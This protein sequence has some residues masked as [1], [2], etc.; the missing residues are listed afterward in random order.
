[1]TRSRFLDLGLTPEQLNLV[2]YFEPREPLTNEGRAGVIEHVATARPALTVFDAYAGLLGVHDLDP[3][4]ERDIE[5]INRHVVD[6]FRDAG[7]T[8]LLLDHV[9]KARENRSRYS[10][11]NGRKLAEVEIHIGME[12]VKHFGRGTTGI[13][14]LRN[15]KDRIGGLPYPVIGELHLESDATTH[16]VTW[17][18]RPAAGQ[19]IDTD[20]PRF[21]PTTLMERVSIHLELQA[22]PVTRNAIEEHVKGKGEYVRLAI[23]CLVDEG[24][25]TSSPGP[26]GS[27]LIESVRPYREAADLVPEEP[28]NGKPGDLVPLRPDLVRPRPRTRLSTSSLVPCL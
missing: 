11:G 6:V 18:I 14:R 25:A 21:R 8:A 22:E 17:E 1:M 19:P 10:S 24:F 15:H 2:H 9:V 3:N 5:R 27:K 12:R 28:H 16:A 26:R 20:T 23:D 13:A 4:S 7:S